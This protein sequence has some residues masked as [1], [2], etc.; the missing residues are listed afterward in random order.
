MKKARFESRQRTEILE[1]AL[2]AFAKKGWK[3]AT[4]RLIGRAAGVNS[5][6]IYYYFENKQSLFRECI[7]FVL[8]GFLAHLRQGLRPFHSGRERTQFLV[9]GV[10]DYFDAHPD[11]IQLIVLA[12]NLHA[13]LFGQ[14]LNTFLKE[15]ALVPIEVLIEGMNRRELRRTNPIQ[16]WWCLLGMCVLSLRLHEVMPYIDRRAAP[17]PLPSMN[18]TRKQVAAL[19]ESGLVV[20]RHRGHETRRKNT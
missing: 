11:R 9:D 16:A 20:P 8:K 4:T 3:G 17:V 6:L 14:A 18:E 5:A 19:L 1:A 13:D 10:F 2:R 15:Q 12:I 7:H